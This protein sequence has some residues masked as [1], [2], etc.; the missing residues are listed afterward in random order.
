MIGDQ[1]L[2]NALRAFL[3]DFRNAY[4]DLEVESNILKLFVVRYGK[5]FK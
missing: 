5:L 4:N 1:S 2:Q 3:V